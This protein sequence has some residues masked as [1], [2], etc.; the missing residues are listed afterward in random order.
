M[1]QTEVGL[2]VSTLLPHNA[3]SHLPPPST[4]F[5]HLALSD[6]ITVLRTAQFSVLVPVRYTNCLIRK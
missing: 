2:A 5:P 1:Q 6:P 3:K 4:V